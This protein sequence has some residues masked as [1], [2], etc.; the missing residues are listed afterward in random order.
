MM[1]DDAHFVGE[2]ATM[3]QPR[4]GLRIPVELPAEVRWKNRSGNKRHVHGVTGNISGNGLFLTVPVRPRRQTPITV[5]VL[6][7]SEVTQIPLELLC[8]G[9]VIR[10]NQPGELVGMGATIDDYELR[11][12]RRKA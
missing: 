6:L 1:V 9:R 12:A 11:P 8:E 3:M 5:T 10:W 2:L 7:P 4:A